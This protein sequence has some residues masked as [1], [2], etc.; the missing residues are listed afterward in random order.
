MAFSKLSLD[1]PS[2]YVR[3][4]QPQARGTLP[5]RVGAPRVLVQAHWLPHGCLRE[6]G[7]ER[8]LGRTSAL[9]GG[10]HAVE[11]ILQIL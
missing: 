1:V 6:G 10:M 8:N 9:I 4:P 11:T 2:A 7:G 5:V 3:R